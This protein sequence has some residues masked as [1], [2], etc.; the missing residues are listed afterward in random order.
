MPYFILLFGD[1]EVGWKEKGGRQLW[2]SYCLFLI[3]FT[4][5]ITKFFLALYPPSKIVRIFITISLS[6]E[7]LGM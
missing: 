6:S 4:F 5:K 2:G 3:C 1:E 7:M